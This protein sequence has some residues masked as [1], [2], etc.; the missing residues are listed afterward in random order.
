MSSGAGAMCRE[1]ALA[2]GSD[3]MNAGSA[4]QKPGPEWR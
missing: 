3:L 4:P 2:G 1:R